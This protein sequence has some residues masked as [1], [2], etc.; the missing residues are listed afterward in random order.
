[1]EMIETNFNSLLSLSL[2]SSYLFIFLLCSFHTPLLFLQ[3]FSAHK[4][5]FLLIQFVMVEDNL[6]LK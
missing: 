2:S 6:N 1:M 5:V 4:L 3:A